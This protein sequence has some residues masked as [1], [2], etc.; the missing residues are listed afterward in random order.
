M[1]ED[2]SQWTF[3]VNAAYEGSVHVGVNSEADIDKALPIIRL[4]REVAR[5]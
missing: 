3:I 1:A 5:A 2:T 4:A